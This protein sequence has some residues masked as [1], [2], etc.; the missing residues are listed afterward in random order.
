M[1][2][3]CSVP[4]VTAIQTEKEAYFNGSAYL[5]LKTPMTLWS[6]SAISFKS[7]RAIVCL[8][9]GTIGGHSQ[10]HGKRGF[11]FAK[12]GWQT[13]WNVPLLGNPC[14]G[15]FLLLSRESFLPTICNCTKPGLERAA[16]TDIHGQLA[17]IVT[18]RL[19][20]KN[21]NSIDLPAF[22]CS[23]SN[24]RPPADHKIEWLNRAA[25][26]SRPSWV[27]IMKNHN[28]I[29]PKDGHDRGAQSSG[30]MCNDVFLWP[31][32]RGSMEKQPEG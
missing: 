14:R 28:K 30:L 5:R 24:H 19:S 7:C 27:A 8:A 11:L 17:F 18:L 3:Q 1:I 31:A 9:I 10:V 23:P 20:S 22:P 16:P 32:Q 21:C 12:L 6:Y 4:T 2:L 29:D 25:Y 15:R 13:V 26:G